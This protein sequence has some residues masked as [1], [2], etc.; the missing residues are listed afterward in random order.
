MML[1]DTTAYTFEMVPDQDALLFSWKPVAGL[2]AALFRT[3]ISEFAHLCLKHRPVRGVIDAQQLDQDSSA[4]AW[5]RG[6]TED[7]VEPYDEWWE[8][9]IF[10]LY[11][12]AGLEKLAVA[13][14][15]PNAPGEVPV[16][17]NDAALRM[18]YFHQ[19]KH[20]YAW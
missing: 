16:P 20:A 15:D 19:L 5:L 9:E 10:P 7:E 8:R 4:F 6:S 12:Q 14:G 11:I 1:T 17:P 13:T 3:A 18:G 2:K